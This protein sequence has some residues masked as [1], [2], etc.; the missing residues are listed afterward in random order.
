VLP[1]F[2]VYMDAKN[3]ISSQ[4]F[5][6]RDALAPVFDNLNQ[7]A[8]TNPLQRPER[9]RIGLARQRLVSAIALLIRYRYVEANVVS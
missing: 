9:G 3:D 4:E 7:Y 1:S 8:A 6:G 5:Q 2:V